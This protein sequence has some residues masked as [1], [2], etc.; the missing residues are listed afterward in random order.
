[1]LRPFTVDDAPALLASY[2]RNREHLLPYDPA[3]PDSFWTLEG[4]QARVADLVRQT[5]AGT[6][7]PC[8]I[9]DGN[10]VIGTMTFNTIVRGPFCS[11]SLG[12]WVDVDETGKGL[13]TSAVAAMLLIADQQLGLHRVDASTMTTNLVSQRV[14]V[15]NGFEKYGTAR[16]YLHIAGRWGDSHLYQRILNDRTPPT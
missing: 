9:F 6:T 2:L 11:T 14:L 8:G 7:F 13:A 12:Y 5:Q 16:N 3:R 10:R 15:K 1:V 4:Q